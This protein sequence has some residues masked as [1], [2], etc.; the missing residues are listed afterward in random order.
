MN[1]FQWIFKEI[2]D[3]NQFSRR[4]LYRSVSNEQISMIF[5]KSPYFKTSKIITDIQ[6]DFQRNEPISVNENCRFFE[7][8]PDFKEIK[9]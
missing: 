2:T 8:F 7:T 4:V 6:S 3:F 9:K 5:I 1:R